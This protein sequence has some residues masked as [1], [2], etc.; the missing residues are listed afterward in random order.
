MRVA[1]VGVGRWGR[2]ILRDLRDLGCEVVAVTSSEESRRRASEGGATLVGSVA[3][4]AE[5]AGVVIATPTA[6]HAAVVGEVLALG[7]P[8]FVEKPLTPD[9]GDADRLAEAA[10][11]RVFMM[12]KWR[13]HPAIEALGSIARSRELGPVH[14]I[15]TQRLQWG[16]VHTD[17]DSTWILMPHDL[18]IVREILGSIPEVRRAVSVDAGG[19][20]V[21]MLAELGPPHCLLE[22]ST[23]SPAVVRRVEVRFEHGSA[24][25]ARTD[26]D[27]ILVARDGTA[28]P[29]RRPIETTLPLHEELRQFVQHLQGGP[30]PKSDA[31]EGALVVR[32]IAEMRKMAG[33]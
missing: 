9:P 30:P 16:N 11:D 1:L 14:S 10:S 6:T 18:S 4:L 15:R 20:E 32:R 12:D 28:E 19:G 21:S 33:L 25:M 8:I 2:H 27:H 17:V 24:A 5:V 22:V 29:E 7:V 23:L 31:G 13:Y 3:E 26:A